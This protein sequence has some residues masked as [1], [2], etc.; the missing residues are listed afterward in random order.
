MEH[1]VLG[2]LVAVLAVVIFFGLR[3]KK[4]EVIVVPGPTPTPPVDPAIKLMGISI[5]PEHV[6]SW[7]DLERWGPYH[8]S[9]NVPLTFRAE[10][11]DP[12]PEDALS[13][14]RVTW[15]LVRA[16]FQGFVVPA[17]SG[18]EFRWSG[19]GVGTACNQKT[20]VEMAIHC[21]VKLTNGDVLQG[22]RTFWLVPESACRK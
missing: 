18:N 2:L 9:L 14:E 21:V 10:T 5:V 19:E 6:P 3:R 7:F 17:V 16:G 4:P 20:P 12:V 1:A 11:H 15:Y 22:S 13:V 8:Y